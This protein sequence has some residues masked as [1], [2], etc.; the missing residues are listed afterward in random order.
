VVVAS[1]D[2]WVREHATNLG[3]VVVSAPM[4]VAVIKPGG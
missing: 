4:L 3:A 2:A 1:S